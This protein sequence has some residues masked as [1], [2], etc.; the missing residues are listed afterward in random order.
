MSTKMYRPAGVPPLSTYYM[1]IT[2]GCNLACR[3][4]WIAPTFEEDG[5]S[6]QCLD[7]ELFKSAIDQAIPLGLGRIKLTGGEPLLHPRF[8][9]M[10]EYATQKGI[11]INL[12]TN[13][14]LIT[15]DLALF[16]KEKTSTYMVSVSIDGI[17]ATT[18]DFLRGVPGSFEQTWNGIDC[19]LGA[20]IQPQVIMSLYP[21]NVDEIEPFIQ[22]AVQAGCSSVKFNIIQS[23]GRG[24]QL[25]EGN[26]LLSIETLVK[27]GNR[28]E[29]ELAG[30][31]SIPLFFSWP[32]AFHSIGRLHRGRGEN[33]N[34]FQILGVLSSGELAMCGIGTL[35][36][37]LTYGHLGRD[38]VAETWAQSPGLVR[39]RHLIPDHL[40]GICSQCIFKKR[41][42]GACPA[43]N[44]HAERRLTAPF[45][46]CRQAD[47]A[48][49][50]PVRRR[51]QIGD[52]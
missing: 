50:F 42:L 28:F 34:I 15:P 33:C 27:L 49:I 7:V 4:C 35:E 51:R 10:A 31:F 5:G 40:E 24:K 20:G 32:M 26:G 8:R 41:C 16:L 29:K 38:P 48:G 45:W 2:G 12:E 37:E 13:G 3:H 36:E 14:T 25:K 19:L 21:D 30:R 52:H 23:S 46:F 44:Y 18:H 9:Q 43:Q 17:S 22:W 47:E 6:G 11:K 39:L 1:Y